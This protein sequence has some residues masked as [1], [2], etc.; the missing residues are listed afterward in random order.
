MMNA[1]KRYSTHFAMVQAG[2]LTIKYV[3]PLKCMTNFLGD[4]YVQTLDVIHLLCISGYVQ[5]S[6]GQRRGYRRSL[7]GH[8]GSVHGQKLAR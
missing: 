5:D 4:V 2:Y 6:D 8:C 1:L 7:L 3:E